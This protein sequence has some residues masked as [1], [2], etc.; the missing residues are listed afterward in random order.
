LKSI[1]LK[2]IISNECIVDINMLVKITNAIIVDLKS[3]KEKDYTILKTQLDDVIF[4]F[5][6]TNQSQPDNPD[7]Q[8]EILKQ[9]EI[10][11]NLDGDREIDHYVRYL[12]RKLLTELNQDNANSQ[13]EWGVK[14][15]YSAAMANNVLL[16]WKHEVYICLD[17][18]NGETEVHQWIRFLCAKLE[19]TTDGE[20]HRVNSIKPPIKITTPEVIAKEMTYLCKLLIK[21][22][23]KPSVK[24]PKIPVEEPTPKKVEPEED[25][26][27][28]PR[29]KT[30]GI[31]FQREEYT[32]YSEYRKA[33]KRC[34]QPFESQGDV[35]NKMRTSKNTTILYNEIAIQCIQYLEVRHF[36]YKYHVWQNTL[37]NPTNQGNIF[38][39]T[40]FGIIFIIIE[41]RKIGIYHEVTLEVY[42]IPG[43]NKNLNA[44]FYPLIDDLQKFIQGGGG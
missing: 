33:L 17:I 29:P 38:I 40:K 5:K 8:N 12:F 11:A 7:I 35:S 27:T 41:Y 28:A 44:I 21:P 32:E 31:D 39:E 10:L 13:I 15:A 37:F 26:D 1:K 18:I 20:S 3:I 43:N 23:K 24:P 34:V 22:E 42:R 19:I 2:D 25:K 6:T 16:N 4:I 14:A 36:A 9:S 30:M